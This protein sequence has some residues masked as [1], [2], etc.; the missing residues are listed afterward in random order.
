MSY[1]EQQPQSPANWQNQGPR[2]G[3]DNRSTASTPGQPTFNKN[4][5]HGQHQDLTTRFTAQMKQEDPTA[6]G[7]QLDGMFSQDTVA[8]TRLRG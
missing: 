4:D 7:S 8:R 3:W 2:Q 5:V 6:F 1:Y